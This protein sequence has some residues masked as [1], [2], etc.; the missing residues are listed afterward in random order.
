[1]PCEFKRT[2][3]V[4]GL[5]IANMV[6]GFMGGMPCTG[7]LVRTGVNIE[8]GAESRASQLINSLYVCAITVLAMDVF[9]YMP[10]PVIASLLI[11]SCW[12]LGKTSMT[13]NN[14][15]WRHKK[16]LDVATLWITC[17][18]CVIFDGAVGL[19]IGLSGRI[20]IKWW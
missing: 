12:N 13:L 10:M 17:A 16:W 18:F 9:V 8:Y 20:M 11:N 15:F 5:S 6:T 14:S 7:V 2:K 4:F 19:L 3:E 1:M